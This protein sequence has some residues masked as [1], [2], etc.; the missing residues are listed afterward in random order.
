MWSTKALLLFCTLLVSAQQRPA[1]EPKYEMTRYVFGIL[2]KGPNWSS[3]STPEAQEIQRGHLANIRKMAEAG[4]LIVA[5]PLSE[6]GDLRGIYIF[7]ASSPEEVRPM[8]NEDP[9]V[10]AGRLVVDLYPW[11]AAA[12]LKVNPPK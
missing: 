1:A 11:F 4:K 9:A 10:K 2:R 8:V 7:N 5:G 12:G 6:A 3:S